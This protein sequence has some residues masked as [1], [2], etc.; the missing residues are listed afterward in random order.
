MRWRFFV[1][2][3][4]IGTAV[5]AA[6]LGTSAARAQVAPAAN[7]G[8]PYVGVVGV[9]I[10]FDG[11]AS[12]GEGL[13]FGWDFGDGTS[14]AGP[15]VA[16]TYAAP[17]VYTVTLTLVD[18]FGQASVAATTATVSSGVAAG[19]S[20]VGCFLT[21]VGFVCQSSVQSGAVSIASLCAIPTV[22]G[23][24]CAA[25]APVEVG[26]VAIAPG[27]FMT[28]VNCPLPNWNQLCTMLNS[29]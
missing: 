6:G 21:D 4:V 23:P 20:P 15:I 13:T 18:A 19:V 12:I 17:G 8:G 11:T 5:V 22:A 14:G 1:L 27:V 3:A 25:I 7:P 29:K 10:Q 28:T 2:V 16:H 9:P 24:L 26:T